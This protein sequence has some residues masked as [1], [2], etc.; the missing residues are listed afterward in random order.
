MLSNSLLDYD[1]GLERIHSDKGNNEFKIDSYGKSKAEM[2]LF[3]I[4]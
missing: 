3:D 1:A 2:N 4:K